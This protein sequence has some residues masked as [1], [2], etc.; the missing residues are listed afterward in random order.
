[1]PKL[2]LS[3]DS[4][5]IA[6]YFRKMAYFAERGITKETTVRQ[7]MVR[8]L[9]DAA[10]MISMEFDTEWT[11]PLRS[12]TKGSTDGAIFLD[13]IPHGYFEAKDIHDNLRREIKKKFDKGYPESNILFYQPNGAILIRDGKEI[14]E[15]DMQTPHAV[16][17]ILN[18][19]FDAQSEERERWLLAQQQFKERIPELARQIRDRITT[20]SRSNKRFQTTFEGFYDQV[21]EALNPN[22]SREATYTMI[23]QHILME[24]IFRTVFDYPE[25]VKRNIIARELETVVDVLASRNFRR[26]DFLR[27]LEYFYETLE[28]ITGS[29]FYDFHQKQYFLQDVYELFFK[30]FSPDTADTHGIVYTPREIVAFMVDS[31]QEL[32]QSRFNT[33]FSDDGVHIFDPFVGTGTFLLGV[34]NAI[35][36]DRLP[37][38]YAHELHCNEVLL[39]PY[40]ISCLN[41]EYLYFERL[42]EQR[43]FEGIC[44]ADT[45]ELAEMKGVSH[46]MFIKENTER[47]RR[48]ARQKMFVVIG[49]P[50]YNANQVNENDNNKN[51]KYPVLDD[52]VSNAYA[53]G[54]QAQKL[55]IHDPYIKAIFL[56]AERVKANGEGIVAFVTNNSFVE[57]IGFDM[58]RKRLAEDFTEIYILNLG[59]NVRKNPKL[60]GTKH[61][62][63]GI[64]VGVSINIF[65]KHKQRK[66]AKKQV[67]CAL[68]YAETDEF[69]T[70]DQK[71]RFLEEVKNIA[72]VE[73]RTL[74]PDA[75]HRWL[76]DGLDN[77]F[78]TLL[79]LGSKNFKAGVNSAEACIFKTFSLGVSTNRDATVYDFDRQNLIRKMQTFAAAYNAERE[80]WTASGRADNI[81]DFVNY[82]ALAWSETLKRR[83]KSG[84][85]MT[86]SKNAIQQSLYRPFAK[87]WLYYDA[88][89]IDRPGQFDEFFPNKQRSD[90]KGNVVL[91][92][93]NF[94]NPKPF[95][96]LVTD[97]IPDLHFTGDSQCFP[98]R[99]YDV[100]AGE[101]RENVTEW[102]L[103][104]F[105][106]EYGQ[107]V[108]REDVFHYVY[109]V[110]HHP[111]YREKYAANL[112]VALPRVP[113]VAGE[114]AKERFWALVQAG[115]ELAEL[116][117]KYEEQQEYGGLEWQETDNSIWKS[118][119]E[120]PY[121]R[122]RIVKPRAE[123]ASEPYI[124]DTDKR[125]RISGFPSEVWE[126]RLGNRSAVEWVVDQYGSD[127]VTNTSV[128]MRLLGQVVTV[129]LR[130]VAIVK[131]LPPLS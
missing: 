122:L 46:E 42:Q 1:M 100:K 102:A 91:S 52:L 84:I 105:R 67:P 86:F 83:L 78:E 56:A 49:N 5:F 27:G 92:V 24:R 107:K 18:K 117:T 17:T 26:E 126:Y 115:R 11:I 33:S 87:Q 7:A 63:F 10:Q 81:D 40:Y 64:Q 28:S 9:G 72:G 38:K 8:L 93:Q 30:H 131:G 29:L 32:L 119:V 129:S 4:P 15:S 57:Q 96:C 124:T 2:N 79:P 98:L 48:Q 43:A 75:H 85:T 6:E 34:M 97:T 109:A 125:L 21:R 77:D 95:H 110:L 65:I 35:T 16:A 41:V 36:S 80:R 103:E 68:H 94:T 104:R 55:K 130:T 111:A 22:L 73:W 123:D 70:R 127:E 114:Q 44:L 69:W 128:L 113:L 47:A 61:N 54:S 45:F 37:H 39:M 13:K 116:H 76:T 19:F 99:T 112:K 101:W 25:F 3:P 120:K 31:V 106:G 71:L 121:R 51:R 20:E 53:K 66:N 90:S 50:P 88:A 62:A 82:D 108:S 12:G 23:V 59:G 74:A 14:A 89:A 58:M 60:S 118:P